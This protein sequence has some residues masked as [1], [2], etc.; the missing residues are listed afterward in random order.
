MEEWKIIEKLR[1][2]KQASVTTFTENKI[3][4]IKLSQIMQ[5]N[6]QNVEPITAKEVKKALKSIRNEEL[7][8]S[9]DVPV[10]LIKY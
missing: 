3:E 9:G 7:A 1:K 5:D 8:G 10:E 2:T 4:R 6:E